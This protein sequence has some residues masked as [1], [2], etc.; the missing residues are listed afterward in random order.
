MDPT[1]WLNQLQSKTGSKCPPFLDTLSDSSLPFVIFGL[2]VFLCV[3]LSLLSNP[4]RFKE[5]HKNG[6]HLIGNRE[7]ESIK[8]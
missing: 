5:H 3:C 7:N 4:C 2:V 8:A 6:V 1:L